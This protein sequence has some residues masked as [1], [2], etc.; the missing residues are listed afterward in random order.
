ML[1]SALVILIL[2]TG[3]PGNGLSGISDPKSKERRGGEGQR[4][5]GGRS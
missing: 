5:Q 3:P 1:T 4:K 2:I